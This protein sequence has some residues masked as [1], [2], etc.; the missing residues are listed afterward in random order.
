MNPLVIGEVFFPD[1]VGGAGRVMAEEVRW[2]TKMGHDVRVITRQTSRRQPL[3][4]KLP[5]GA[6]IHRFPVDTR[7]PQ[8]LFRTTRSGIH[9]L[10]SRVTRDW[11]PT[12]VHF[13]QPHVAHHA[14]QDRLIQGLPTLATFHS[15]WADEMRN[16]GGLFPLLAP[17]A[18]RLERSALSSVD[19]IIVLSEYSR[20]RLLRIVDEPSMIHRIP[21]GVDPERFP[22]KTATPVGRPPRILTIRNLVP[23]MGIESL[24]EAAVILKIRNRPVRLTIGGEGPLRPTLESRAR[25]LGDLCRFV[26]HIP[27]RELAR[28]YR[29]ADLFV[30]PSKA[31]EGFGLVILE[32][33]ASGT[34]V[35]GTPVGAIPE[36]VGLQGTGFVTA[37]VGAEALADGIAALL[38]RGLPE[39]RFLRAIAESK[40]WRKRSENLLTVFSELTSRG[41]KSIRDGRAPER[42]AKDGAV[43]P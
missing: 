22:C 4:E 14:L 10:V 17:I 2:L 29:E 26:G 32:S 18:A 6:E 36:L 7:T 30:I 24:I 23:R 34:P 27:E 33:F 9:E 13:H 12:L 40:T 3:Y 21:G 11:H 31:I 16:R 8:G 39:P 35:L 19:R 15:S 20:R 5:D 43:A 38:E 1:T 41:R 25:D 42:E 37:G 28:F